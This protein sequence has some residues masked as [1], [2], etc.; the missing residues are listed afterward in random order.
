MTGNGRTAYEQWDRHHAMDEVIQAA[1]AELH[2]GKPAVETK[3]L[4]YP[5]VS[6]PVEKDHCEG[7][8]RAIWYERSP[9]GVKCR[10]GL[11]QGIAEVVLDVWVVFNL[12]RR[13]ECPC[14][15]YA[16]IEKY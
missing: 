7:N 10:L 4:P 1:V 16:R 15:K 5:K 11:H 14:G 9:A 2:K 8:F 13:L 6:R 12:S 3:R